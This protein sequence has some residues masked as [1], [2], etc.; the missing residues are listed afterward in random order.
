M[1]ARPLSELLEAAFIQSRDMDASLA[2]RLQAF[3]DQVRAMG[4][5]F[6]DS[7]DALVARLRDFEVGEHAPKPGEPMPSFVLPDENGHLVSLEDLLERG[8]VAV[9]F[10][11]GHWCPYCR[12]NTRALAEAQDQIAA[13]GGQIAAIMPDRQHYTARLQAESDASF[14]ILTDFENGY[15]MSLGLAF[16]VGTEMQALMTQAGWDVAPSQGSDTWLLP[17]PA[18]FVVGTDGIVTARF[19]DPDYRKRMAIE[20]LVA[21]LRDAP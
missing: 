12:I 7:V 5:V 16:W 10:H 20:D 3:A 13:A 21:A 18:T 17:I 14:P 2:D 19:V 6:Q 4:A 15:A 9:T 1:T 8:P 11:R